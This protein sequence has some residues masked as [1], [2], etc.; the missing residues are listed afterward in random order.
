VSGPRAGPPLVARDQ[1]LCRMG[2]G[3]QLQCHACIQCHDIVGL[4]LLCTY[5]SIS[6]S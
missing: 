4:I 5:D 2:R 3:G 1:D 6:F